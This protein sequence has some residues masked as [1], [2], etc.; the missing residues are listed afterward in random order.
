MKALLTV[1]ST[2]AVAVASQFAVADSSHPMF[3]TDRLTIVKPAV[4]SDVAVEQTRVA[5]N[6]RVVFY[7]SDIQKEVAEREVVRRSD[8]IVFTKSAS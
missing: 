4:K 3:R 5:R 6:D 7:K 1:V 2:V 8:R